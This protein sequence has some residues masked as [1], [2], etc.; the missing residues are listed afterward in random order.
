MILKENYGISL[1]KLFIFFFIFFLTTQ[2]VEL[3]KAKLCRFQHPW[4]TQNVKN[5]VLNSPSNNSILV[6]LSFRF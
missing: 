6:L 4:P 3:D 5:I 2:A 1:P